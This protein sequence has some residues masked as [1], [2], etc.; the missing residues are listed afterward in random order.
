M[1]EE[2]A[3]KAVDLLFKMYEDN[4]PDAYINKDTHGIILDFIGGEPL[5]NVEI[6]DYIVSY[7]IQQCVEKNHEW[8]TAFRV[9]FASNGILYF[10]EEV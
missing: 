1:S 3:K 6:M 2:T 4:N 8:L 5:M 9:G 7:F 10:E